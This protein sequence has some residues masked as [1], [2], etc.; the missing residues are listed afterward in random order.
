MKYQQLIQTGAACEVYGFR[1]APINTGVIVRLK[2]D[3][4]A[5]FEKAV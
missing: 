1:I 4:E 3:R 2:S 5:L